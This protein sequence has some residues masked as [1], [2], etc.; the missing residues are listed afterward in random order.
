MAT[1]RQPRA[2]SKSIYKPNMRKSRLLPIHTLAAPSRQ[3]H[4]AKIKNAMADAKASGGA[5]RVAP[6]KW[7]IVTATPCTR[8]AAA[9][10]EEDHSIPSWIGSPAGLF[11]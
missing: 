6:R 2:L 1:D 5:G 3:A 8:N 9:S 4:T 7:P 11:G 10:M